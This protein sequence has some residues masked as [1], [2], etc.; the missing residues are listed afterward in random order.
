MDG[1]DMSVGSGNI[2]AAETALSMASI[3][4]SSWSAVA[5]TGIVVVA[6]DVT[7]PSLF[8]LTFLDDLQKQVHADRMAASVEPC[9]PRTSKQ[10]GNRPNV[11]TTCT[12]T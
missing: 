4:G 5:V 10:Q 6:S 7:W 2:N 9:N 1:D 11:V 12:Y 3:E 8:F